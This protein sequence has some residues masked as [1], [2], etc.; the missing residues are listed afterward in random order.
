EPQGGTCGDGCVAIVR[1]D[2]QPE[3]IEGIRNVLGWSG[4]ASTAS[5]IRDDYT[6]SDSSRMAQLLKLAMLLVLPVTAVSLLVSTVDG[7]MERRRSLAVLSAIG[8][9]GGV[10]RRSVL[11]QLSLP[12]GAGLVLAFGTGL[13]VTD[14]LFRIA[15]EPVTLPVGLLLLT[16]A[17][18]AVSVIVVTAAALP[19][20]H[21]V[22][23]PGLLR[24]E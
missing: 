22:C 13:A 6:H 5:Q 7:M 11:V 21:I 16:T 3:S 14:L 1:T 23:G 2:G 12:L 9:P 24:T 18:A 20:V 8:V 4:E 19:W 15:A 17:A 10:L